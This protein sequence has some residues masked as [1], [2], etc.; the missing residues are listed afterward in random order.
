MNIKKETLSCLI[1]LN[2]T[3]LK[4]VENTLFL[5]VDTGANTHTISKNV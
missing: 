2:I 1:K 4:L 5:T 3:S